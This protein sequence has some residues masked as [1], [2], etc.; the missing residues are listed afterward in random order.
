MI[1]YYQ[2][3][4]LYK[5]DDTSGHCR[6]YYYK[7]IILYKEG[8]S[9]VNVWYITIRESSYTK[10][11][12]SG[13]CII[14]YY[15]GIII[16]KEDDLIHNHLRFKMIT[17]LVIYFF[18]IYMPTIYLCVCYIHHYWISS[19][20]FVKLLY[21]IYMYLCSVRMIQ[22]FLNNDIHALLVTHLF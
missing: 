12:T 20:V 18:K 16:Y 1:H 4:I 19:T 9:Q 6:I 17:S 3:I 22:Y 11:M 14:Y 2:G 8:W 5:E 7:R 13:Q 10:R 21:Y 15:Q